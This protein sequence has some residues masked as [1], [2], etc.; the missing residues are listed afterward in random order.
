MCGIESDLKQAIVE[1]SMMD[2]CKKCASYGNVINVDKPK[3]HNSFDRSSVPRDM[4]VEEKIDF[5]VESAGKII[6]EG[7]ENKKFQKSQLASMVCVK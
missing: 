1:G 5:V 6:K 4:Y 3:L 7:R 2:L